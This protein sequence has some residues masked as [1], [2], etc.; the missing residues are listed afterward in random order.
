[1]AGHDAATRQPVEAEET[2]VVQ[3]KKQ[4]VTKKRVSGFHCQV[5]ILVADPKYWLHFMRTKPV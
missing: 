4:P 5:Q 2:R 1:M 3:Q